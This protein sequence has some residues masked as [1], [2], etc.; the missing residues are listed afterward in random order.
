[1]NTST[2]ATTIQTEHQNPTPG[3][4]T[5]VRRILLRFL[6]LQIPMV[7][8]ALVCYLLGRLIPASSSYATVY[9][10]GTY[11]YAAGDIFFLTVPVVV[12]LVC[13]RYGWQHS[14]ELALA[15]IAPVAVIIVLGQL[16]AYAYIPW[17][18]I[19]DYPAMCLGMV[20]YMLYRRDHFT[21]WMRRS[22][23][24]C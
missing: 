15:M 21:G 6:E 20:I 12:W 3:M 4:A 16:A 2:T 14:L 24:A 1:M 7:F 8:G 9:H 13:R 23:H 19:A 18:V 17:L 5:P 10:A 11:L 22:A